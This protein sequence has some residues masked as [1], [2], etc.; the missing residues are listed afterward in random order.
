MCS[1]AVGSTIFKTSEI[2]DLEILF[3][4]IICFNKEFGFFLKYLKDFGLS[5]QRINGVGAQGH[6]R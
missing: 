2:Q 5:K 3:I 1:A 6:V 4:K